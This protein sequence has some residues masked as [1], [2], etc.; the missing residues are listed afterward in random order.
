MI[1]IYEG[2]ENDLIIPSLDLRVLMARRSSS[3]VLHKLLKKDI[4]DIT[5]GNIDTYSVKNIEDIKMGELVYSIN[6]DTNEKELKQITALY[7]GLTDEVYEIT[8]GDEV[9]KTTPKHE[10]YIVDKGWIRAYELEIGDEIVST[11]DEKMIIKKIVHKT[12]QE[13]TPVYNLTVDGNHT[14]LITKYSLLVHNAGSK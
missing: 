12:N 7:T 8:I 2:K 14:Y 13:L 3:N 4:I 9:I 5:S 10:F 11:G 6:V 1:E